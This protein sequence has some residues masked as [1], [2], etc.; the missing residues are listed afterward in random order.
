MNEIKE[1]LEGIN[2]WLGDI[3]EC[4]SEVEYRRVKITQSKQQREKRSFK[5]TV[6]LKDFWDNIKCTNIYTMGIPE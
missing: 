1:I 4:L 3:E 5:C 2:R 6:S